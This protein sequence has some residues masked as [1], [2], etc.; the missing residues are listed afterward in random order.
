MTEKLYTFKEIQKAGL[1]IRKGSKAVSRNAN[2]ECLFASSQLWDP[3]VA[4]CG[5][6]FPTSPSEDYFEDDWD[7]V[8]G[9]D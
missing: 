9:I 5:H 1:R 2:G 8:N 3:E 4:Y 7:F 6:L